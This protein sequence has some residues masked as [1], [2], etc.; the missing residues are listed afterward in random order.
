M[1][2]S[3]ETFVST[4]KW[5]M[6]QCRIAGSL[7]CPRPSSGTF[8]PRAASFIVSAIALMC[9]S[10]TPFIDGASRSLIPV[11]SVRKPW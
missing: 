2:R 7:S 9:L 6:S 8:T 4:T 1:M 11:R 3:P 5:F 10:V